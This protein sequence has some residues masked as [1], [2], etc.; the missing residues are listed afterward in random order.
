[1]PEAGDTIGNE[2][3]YTTFGRTPPA[4]GPRQKLNCLRQKSNCLETPP[5]VQLLPASCLRQKCSCL[6]QKPF[7]LQNSS[8]SCLLPGSSQGFSLHIIFISPCPDF[9][10]AGR[11]KNQGMAQARPSPRKKIR[12]RPGPGRPRER[13]IRAWPGPGRLRERKS[14][15]GPACPRKKSG[16]GPKIRARPCRWKQ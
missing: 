16:H 2:W 5:G 1:M 9:Y 10:L 14:G 6:R 12:A 13:K 4:W 3:N 8:P 11:N 15:H 7:W